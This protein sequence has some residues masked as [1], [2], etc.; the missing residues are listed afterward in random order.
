[1]K[2][3]KKKPIQIQ[4]LSTDEEPLSSDPEPRLKIRQGN[5]PYETRNRRTKSISDEDIENERKRLATEKERIK[6]NAQEVQKDHDKAVEILRDLKIREA[7]LIDREWKVATLEIQY[8]ARQKEK[9]TDFTA[10]NDSYTRRINDSRT[11]AR[12]STNEFMERNTDYFP[13]AGPFHTLQEIIESNEFLKGNHY[14]LTSSEAKKLAKNAVRDYLEA[15]HKG[16]FYDEEIEGLWNEQDSKRMASDMNEKSHRLFQYNFRSNWS[17]TDDDSEM[18]I[19]RDETRMIHYIF[20]FLDW[21]GIKRRFIEAQAQGYFQ[22]KRLGAYLGFSYTI[23]GGRLLHFVRAMFVYLYEY[24]NWRLP[25]VSEKAA[26][27]K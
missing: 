5:Q 25:P 16:R 26:P 10:E 17:V 20:E 8:A 6:R 22:R 1:M 13:Q 4:T 3:A 19:T 7:D 12:E 2:R 18:P 11:A 21:E 27:R 15:K 24:M 14:G 9:W 23:V